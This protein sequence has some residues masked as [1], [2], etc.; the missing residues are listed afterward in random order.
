HPEPAPADPRRRRRRRR[1]D[2]HRHVPARPAGRPAQ[3]RHRRDPALLMSLRIRPRYAPGGVVWRLR[4]RVSPSRVLYQR[5]FRFYLVLFALGI[6]RRSLKR[7]DQFLSLDR[8]EAG[9]GITIR[10]I[11]V[12]SAKERKRLMR[13]QN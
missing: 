10:T 8:I 12:R 9:Q 4:A 3:E 11:P 5:F 2:P 6:L 7:R 13:G 1:A